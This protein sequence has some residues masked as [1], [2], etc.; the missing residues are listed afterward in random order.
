MDTLSLFQNEREIRTVAAGE[1]LFVEGESGSTAFVVLEGEMQIEVQGHEVE[2][3]GPGEIFGEMA[4]I[5]EEPRSATARA[6]VECRLAVL[7][8]RRFQFLVQ[9][10]PRFALH[11]MKV[12]A[13]RLR[14][15]SRLTP[16]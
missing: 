9:Q 2:T 5:T 1:T 11:L 7:D 10:T 14:R 4:I 12:M 8:G 13:D 16:A 3:L 6:L 15:T